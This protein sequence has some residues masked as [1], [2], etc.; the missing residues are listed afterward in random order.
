[1]IAIGWFF[2]VF[3]GIVNIF[4]R[5]RERRA[6]SFI[7]MILSLGFLLMFYAVD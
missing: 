6:M 2:L 4:T 3:G 1:M 7:I 5:N